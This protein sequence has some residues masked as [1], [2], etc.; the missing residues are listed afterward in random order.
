MIYDPH[1]FLIVGVAILLDVITGISQ[2][3]FNKVLSSE[4][5]RNGVYHKLSYV[6]AVA[7]ALFVEYTVDHLDIGYTLPLF[8]PVCTYIVLTEIVSI[9]ENMGKLNPE[10][11][12]SGIFKLLS[13]NKNRRIDDDKD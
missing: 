5:M 11:T 6:F 10:L 1:I 9:I 12:G 8:V 4:K 13:E 2:A 7:L 3:V